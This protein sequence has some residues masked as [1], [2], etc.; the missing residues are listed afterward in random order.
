MKLKIQFLGCIKHITSIV[1]YRMGSTDL[2]D[3]LVEVFT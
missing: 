3:G 1:G 2:K